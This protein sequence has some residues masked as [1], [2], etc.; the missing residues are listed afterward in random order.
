MQ[1]KEMM[2]N[3]G[4]KFNLPLKLNRL[5]ILENDM[6]QDTLNTCIVDK[7]KITADNVDKL[8]FEE[9]AEVRC[10][11]HAL[12]IFFQIILFLFNQM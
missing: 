3:N 1:L 8:T 10:F 9:V 5:D 12:F 6:F 11:F 4:T 2:D 7:D